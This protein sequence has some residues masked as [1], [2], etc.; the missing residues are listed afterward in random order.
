M[1][2]YKL[3]FECDSKDM[4]PQFYESDVPLEPGNIILIEETGMYHLIF[5]TKQLSNITRLNLSKSGEDEKDA[6]LLARDYEH[7]GT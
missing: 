4:N 2:R 5:S 7:W 1:A 3:F 6:L